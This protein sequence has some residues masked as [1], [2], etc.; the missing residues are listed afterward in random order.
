[1]LLCPN[2][3]VNAEWGVSVSLVHITSSAFISYW[4]VGIRIFPRK[5]GFF[6]FGHINQAFR[7][8]IVLANPPLS[9]LIVMVV[10]R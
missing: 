10:K 1:L 8:S 9:I 6:D 3:M 4:S 2:I 5:T 7:I